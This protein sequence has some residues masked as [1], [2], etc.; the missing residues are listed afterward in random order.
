M[1]D[2]VVYL[3]DDDPAVLK[4]MH[5]LV[6]SANF[7]AKSLASAAL[8]LEEYDAQRPGCLILDVRMPH[9][10]GLQLQ[11]TLKERGIAMPVIIMTGHSDVA[12]CTESFRNGAFDFIEKPADDDFLV[13]RIHMAI[14]ADVERRQQETQREEIRVR[15]ATLTPREREVMDAIVSGKSQK[16]I[17]SE[18][19]ISFQ[20][21]AKHRA[22]VLSKLQVGNDVE[23]VRT[24]LLTD[25][26]NPAST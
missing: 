15:L 1:T 21:A 26:V 20:T 24:F 5:W 23:V 22:K 16:R 19:G 17:A 7:S 13:E 2:A 9:M 8:F 25:A 3:V 6:E 11:S 10:T 4:S 18:L 12:T 14:A